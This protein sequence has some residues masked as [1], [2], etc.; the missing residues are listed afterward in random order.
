MFLRRL[1]TMTLLPASLAIANDQPQSVFPEPER[2]V[3]I[4]DVHGDYEALTK[5]L[6][7]M[8]LINR[9]ND[10]IGG[11]TMLIQLGDFI[12]RGK[13]SRQVMDLL[14]KLEIQAEH[15]GGK[16][17]VL[18]G[19]HES[20]AI[21]G[22]YS[23]ITYEDAHSF[24]ELIDHRGLVTAKAL[25]DA[26][27]YMTSDLSPYGRWLADRPAMVRVGR[28][29]YVHAGIEDWILNVDLHRMN[30]MMRDWMRFFQNPESNRRPPSRTYWLLGGDGPLQTR[31]LSRGKTARDEFFEWMEKLGLDAIVVGHTKVKD[32][33]LISTNEKYGSKLIMAD[34]GISEAKGGTPT[35]IE[36]L[37]GEPPRVHHISR[38]HLCRQNHL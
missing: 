15:G 29:L 3:V 21:R 1:I 34:T 4:G 22:E 18:L 20:Y 28:R 10:W 36:I 27:K 16:V 37:R 6:R 31:E 17:I 8:K 13:Q 33:S 38:V 32:L 19:N 7:E 26:L 5:I 14:M 9:H 25:K 12:A 2:L 35:A 11:D 30:A 24:L 23:M